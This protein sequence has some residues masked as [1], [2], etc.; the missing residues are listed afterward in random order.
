MIEVKYKIVNV[1]DAEDYGVVAGEYVN[2]NVLDLVVKELKSLGKEIPFY[3][4]EIAIFEDGKM[5]K[6]KVNGYYQEV[7]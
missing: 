4:N 3:G 5:V 6:V 2:K 1:G 7:K